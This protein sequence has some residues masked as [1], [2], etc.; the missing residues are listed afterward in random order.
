[1]PQFA[2]LKVDCTRTEPPSVPAL[3]FSVMLAPAVTL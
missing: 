1:L 3:E 2:G